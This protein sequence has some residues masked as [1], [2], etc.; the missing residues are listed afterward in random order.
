MQFKAII[1][2]FLT[3]AASSSQAY[4][5]E[6]LWNKVVAFAG[7]KISNHKAS[8]IALVSALGI[9]AAYYC[10]KYCVSKRCGSVL[11]SSDL[12]G[13]DQL[14]EQ[15]INMGTSGC[16]VKNEYHIFYRK[17]DDDTGFVYDL[18]RFDKEKSEFVFL[19][20]APIMRIFGNK[21]CLVVLCAG[22]E[23]MIYEIQLYVNDE[24][25][26][27]PVVKSNYPELYDVKNVSINKEYELKIS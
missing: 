8:C 25:I 1:V 24:L 3:V 2:F 27:L 11:P 20:R 18:K 10:R 14:R 15:I 16:F 19:A 13:N 17:H 21:D 9:A 23:L 22:P 6:G 12:T 5:G 7:Q 26:M 4:F